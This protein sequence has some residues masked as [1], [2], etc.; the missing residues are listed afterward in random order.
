[1]SDTVSARQ[2]LYQLSNH[3]PVSEVAPNA[4]SSHITDSKSLTDSIPTPIIPESSTWKR[5]EGK[6]IIITGCNSPTGIG[7]ASAYLFA[8]NGARAIYICDVSATHLFSTHQP[9]L[10]RRFPHVDI[11]ARQFDA[12]DEQA[13]RS[14]VDDA[15]RRYGRLDVFFANAGIVSAASGSGS[16]M[17]PD[18][19]SPAST[20]RPQQRQQQQQQQPKRFTDLSVSEFER[21]MHVN[22]TSVFLALKYATPAMLLTSSHPLPTVTAVPTNLPHPPA[23]PTTNTLPNEKDRNDTRE[24]K[25][26]PGGSFITTSS[27]AGLRSNAGPSD[28]SAS[29]AAVISL[30]QTSCYQ[31]AGTGVRCNAICPGLIET[32]MTRVVFEG[33]RQ[34][35]TE[36][37]IG[38]VNPLKRAG[39]ADEVAQLAVFLASEESSYVNGQAVPVDGGLSAGLPGVVGKMG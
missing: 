35:G 27:V 32:G 11:H 2:R 19:I 9:Q 3:L 26:T 17:K 24:P 12:A 25:T 15:V 23:T 33:A 5:L 36:S 20:P 10:S 29:K 37:K 18:G 31:L 28:Y 38:Q 16:D 1:M 39:R 21:M 34:R 4:E 22:V 14:V 8:V 13:V 30:I 7:I 6:V